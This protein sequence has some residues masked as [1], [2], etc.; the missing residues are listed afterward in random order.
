LLHSNGEVC[1]P[2][3]CK[4]C[5]GEH[6]DKRHGGLANCCNSGIKLYNYRDC[7]TNPPPCIIL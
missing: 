7:K 5:G 6:C 4:Q 1:C 3:T 2:L